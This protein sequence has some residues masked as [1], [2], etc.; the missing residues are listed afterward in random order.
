MPG[1]EEAVANAAEQVKERMARDLPYQ[2]AAALRRKPDRRP[3]I[4]RKPRTPRGP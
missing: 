3:T 1:Y 4:I 2:R